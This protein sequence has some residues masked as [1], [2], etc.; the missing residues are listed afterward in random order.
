M[1]DGSA[2]DLSQCFVKGTEKF[3]ERVGN[4]AE[5]KSMEASKMPR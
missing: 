5:G 4:D 2:R 3:V 1:H